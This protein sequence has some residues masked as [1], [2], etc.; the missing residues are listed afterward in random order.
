MSKN[1]NKIADLIYENIEQ[2]KEYIPEYNGEAKPLSPN[3]K[4]KVWKYMNKIYNKY[5]SWVV[6]GVIRWDE[7]NTDI[8]IVQKELDGAVHHFGPQSHAAIVKGIEQSN[9]GFKKKGQFNMEENVESTFNLCAN[10]V[11]DQSS[12]NLCDFAKKVESTHTKTEQQERAQ[13]V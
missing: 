3:S 13:I 6:D 12:K 9:E 7:N 10:Q 1:D 5:N 4:D 2:L 8:P 11:L